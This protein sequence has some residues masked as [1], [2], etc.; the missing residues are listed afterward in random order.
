LIRGEVS[1]EGV[2]LISLTL[3]GKEWPAI[4]D[5]GFNGDL[6]LPDELLSAIPHEYLGRA[7]STLAEDE[8]LVEIVFD[9]V[10]I[11]AEATFVP[12]EKA[13]VGTNLLR[14]HRI[15]IDFPA[16]SILMQRV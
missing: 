4:V 12:G 15:T 5:T 9:G 3:A 11:E 10:Q 14:D 13:L 16:G 6:E 8:Y 2:P 7:L 1:E